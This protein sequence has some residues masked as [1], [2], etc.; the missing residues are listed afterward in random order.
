MA[1]NS[2]DTAR[3][4]NI[5]GIAISITLPICPLVEIGSHKKIPIVLSGWSLTSEIMIKAMAS[6]ISMTAVVRI[7]SK[8]LT[9]NMVYGP[10]D[11]LLVLPVNAQHI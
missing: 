6:A 9:L 7:T 3:P 5:S 2:R 11:L 4:V 8:Y 1:R 10:P